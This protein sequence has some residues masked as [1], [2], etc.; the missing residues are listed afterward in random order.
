M[1][2]VKVPTNI[3]KETGHLV[4]GLPYSSI[5]AGREM[6]KVLRDPG[7]EISPKWLT[8]SCIISKGFSRMG[9]LA[10]GYSNPQMFGGY[11][12]EGDKRDKKDVPAGGMRIGDF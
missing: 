11:Y 12:Q 10:L 6:F 7:Y 8:R 3:V 1:P 2:I 9:L 4:G 5:L